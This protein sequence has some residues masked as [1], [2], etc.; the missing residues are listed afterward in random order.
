MTQTIQIGAGLTAIR[1][2]VTVASIPSGAKI[3]V[4]PHTN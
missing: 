1:F 4:K 3:V 2:L